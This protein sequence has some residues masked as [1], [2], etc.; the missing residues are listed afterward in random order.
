MTEKR[1]ADVI[2]YL[3]SPVNNAFYVIAIIALFLL[4]MDNVSDFIIT[5]IVAFFFLCITPVIG[6]LIYTKKGIVDIWVSDQRFR[7]PFYL[8]AILGYIIAIILFYIIDQHEFFVLTLA[9]LFVTM[10]ITLSN[11]K[12]K[13]SS[14]TAGL[15]GPFTAAFYLFGF[16]SLPLFLLLP[17]II[18]ARLKL[19]AHSINQLYG[20]ALIGCIVT[21]ATYLNFY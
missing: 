12:T 6:I 2:S 14:H 5:F 8:V 10:T 13:M 7:T 3:L 20:G 9:Y 1:A 18:W 16:I 15:T 4:K 11:L 21:Y 17:V 19:N